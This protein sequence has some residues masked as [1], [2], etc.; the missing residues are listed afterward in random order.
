LADSCGPWQ[1]AVL[2]QIRV[3]PLGYP[4]HLD[5][6]QYLLKNLVG[7]ENRLHLLTANLNRGGRSTSMDDIVLPPVPG[8]PFGWSAQP[9]RTSDN[10]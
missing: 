6:E 8:S 1:E 5:G 9:P 7:T 2:D 10:K 3:A 4:Y